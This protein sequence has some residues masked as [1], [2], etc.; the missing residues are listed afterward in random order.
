MN[1]IIDIV[2][3]RFEEASNSVQTNLIAMLNRY[4]KSKWSNLPESEKQTNRLDIYRSIGD[5]NCGYVCTHVNNDE[6]EQINGEY[7]QHNEIYNGWDALNKEIEKYESKIL[8]NEEEFWLEV[9]QIYIEWFVRNW[10]IAKTEVS[11]NTSIQY[12]LSENN[13]Q[14]CFDLNLLNWDNYIDNENYLKYHELINELNKKKPNVKKRIMIDMIGNEIDTLDRTLEKDDHM[15]V[16]QA[17]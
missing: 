13:S 1:E 7:Y 5:Y 17:K 3:A 2:K 14:R 6:F 10:E 16:F 11:I 15:I 4:H 12:C 8:E 9:E